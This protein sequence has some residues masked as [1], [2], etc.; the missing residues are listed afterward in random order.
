MADTATISLAHRPA[1]LSRA[2]RSIRTD[3]LLREAQATDDDERRTALLDEVILINRCVAEAIANRYR[4]RGVATEDLHQAAFEGL[5]KAVQK[6]DPSVRPDL[7]TYAVPTIRGEVQRWFRDQS[8][9]VRP[10]RRVQELQW[11]VN[12][13]VESL[14][15]DLGREPTDVELSKDVGCSRKE[16]DQTLQAYGCFQPSSLD[17]PVGDGSGLTLGELLQSED[18]EQSAAEARATLGP[19]LQSLSERDRDILFLRFFEER[20][21]KDIGELLGVTQMQVSRLLQRILGDLR[22]QIAC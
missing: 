14:S 9:M 5:V 11:R 20:S 17:K 13:S 3:E 2:E 12:R 7:L 16:L 6:F 15:Q 10:P 8:W 19:V 1:Q 4:G 18:A 21:Q 22:T